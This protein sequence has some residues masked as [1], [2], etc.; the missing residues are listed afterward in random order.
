LHKSGWETV[1]D[2]THIFEIV[3]PHGFVSAL[4]LSLP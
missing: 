2:S 1:K 3:Q 4:I